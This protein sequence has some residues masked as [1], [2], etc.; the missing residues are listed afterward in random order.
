MKNPTKS[1]SPTRS[2]LASRKPAAQNAPPDFYLRGTDMLAKEAIKAM[3]RR[4]LARHE[5]RMRG[6]CKKSKRITNP[7]LQMEA[8]AMKVRRVLRDAAEDVD[9]RLEVML[10]I[11]KEFE[12]RSENNRQVAEGE[13][14]RVEGCP[15]PVYVGPKKAKRLKLRCILDAQGREIDEA[16]NLIDVACVEV[17][18]IGKGRAKK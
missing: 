5:E 16:G 11:F 6:P 8:W 14:V 10:A 17:P 1:T 2:K 4:E 12:R 18:K 7:R 3:H 15:C 13:I 9:R